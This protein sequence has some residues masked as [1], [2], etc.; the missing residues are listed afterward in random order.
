MA[1][2]QLALN[3]NKT[4]IIHFTSKFKKSIPL[5]SLNINGA[6]VTT[7]VSVRDLGFYFDHILSME[8][9][10]SYVCKS[11]SFSL[12]RISRIQKFL[13]QTSTERLIHAFV[14]SRLDYCNSLLYN[15]P[16]T[17]T[18]RLQLLQNSAARLVT[19]TKRHHHITPILYDLHWLPV[20][21]RIKFKILLLTFK[22]LNN[23]APAYLTELLERNNSNRLTRQSATVRLL[24]PRFNT[25]SYGSRSFSSAAPRLWNNLPNNIRN[26]PSL[27]CFKSALKT[28]LFTEYYD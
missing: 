9:H 7:S 13:D 27:H 6:I 25:Q 18:K 1:H 4:E 26:A 24:E 10:I 3:G 21:Q 8:Q 11:V 5:A 2:N 12:Y 23:Q 17:L 19:R 15:L 20:C 28:F 14:T 22:I 16:N